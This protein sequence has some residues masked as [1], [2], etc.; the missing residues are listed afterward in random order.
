MSRRPTLPA[1]RPSI[2]SISAAWLIS[3]VASVGASAAG[4]IITVTTL[5]D[6][7]DASPG[8]ANLPGP[9]GKVSM[10]EAVN[11]ANSTP[12]PQTIHFAIPQSEFWL[13]TSMALLRIEDGAFSLNDDGTTIDFTTQTAFTG[14]TNPNGWEVGAYGLQPNAWGIAAI[15]VNGDNCTIK[16]MGRVLQRGSGV[17]ITGSNNRVIGCTISGPL[18]AAVEIE[19]FLGSGTNA[20]GNVIGG[21]LPEERNVLSAGNAGIR[22]DGASHNNVVIG[23]TLVGSP[24]AGIQVRGAYCCPDYTPMNNRIGGPTPEE[25]N[26]IAHNGKYGEEGFPLGT[27]VQVEYAIGTVVEGNL[28]GTTQDGTAMYPGGRGTAGIGVR[29]SDDTIIRDNVVSGIR[30]VGVN[31]YAGDVFGVGVSIYGACERT[32]IQGNK[33]GVAIDGVTPIVSRSSLSIG[34]FPGEGSPID[35]V[36]GGLQ[37]G[38]ANI[39]ANAETFG[40]AVVAS[41]QRTTISANSISNHS[42]L[43]IDVGASGVTNVGL[44]MLASAE[45]DSS[46]ITISG[47]LAANAGQTYRI[48]FFASD[49]CD[50]SG[51]GEGRTF[52]GSAQTTTNA[53]GAASFSATLSAYVE[54]GATITATATSLT[55][56]STSEFSACITASIDAAVFGDLDGDGFVNFADLNLLLGS[57][58]AIGE[59]M[60]GDLD[61]DGDIDFADLNLLLNVYNQGA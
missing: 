43:G 31:H 26:W 37:P 34:S 61:E 16:G 55:T 20:T 57:Y 60:P 15:F 12:G 35:T 13:D 1:F 56:L 21:T 54:D 2:R 32:T 40:V 6:V 22:I 42:A 47:T 11:A 49:A 30:R 33:I 28:I 45:G 36:I 14:D 4:E 25:A 53:S 19:T 29:V 23:N 48:E 5:D 3:A 41:A 8:I 46:S 58:N 59:N 27:Q 52:L 39:I 9:D 50:P 17:T 10:R 44:P 18:Y 51:F 24:F 7:T 38:Q